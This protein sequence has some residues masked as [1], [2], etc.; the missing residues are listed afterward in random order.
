MQEP[1]YPPIAPREVEAIVRHVY[2]SM[3][4]TLANEGVEEEDAMQAVHLHLAKKAR[5][6]PSKSKASSYA[7]LLA[8]SALCSLLKK[9]RSRSW[10]RCDHYA[11]VA[12]SHSSQAR[13]QYHEL[14]YNAYIDEVSKQMPTPMMALVVRKMALGET[15]SEIAASLEIGNTTAANLIASIR[16]H[17]SSL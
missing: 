5:F 7:T 17:L 11:D 12:L 13:N 6:D 8:Y 1:A 15:Q 14:E 2:R 10:I 9:A 16:S 4:V 3:L